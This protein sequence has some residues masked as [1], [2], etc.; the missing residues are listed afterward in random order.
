MVKARQE[1][2]GGIVRGFTI[3]S[4]N[5]NQFDAQ[6]NLASELDKRLNV[7]KKFA[8]EKG[9][10]AAVQRAVDYVAGNAP[11][12]H[13]FATAGNEYR[14]ELVESGYFEG[15]VTADTNNL[16]DKALQEAQLNVIKSK[17]ESIATQDFN[18]ILL[19]EKLRLDAGEPGDFNAAAGQI[20][21][22]VNG[23]SDAL[24]GVDGSAALDVKATLAKTGDTYYK[25]IGELHVEAQARRQKQ[26]D[27]VTLEDFQQE[28]MLQIATDGAK[29]AVPSGVIDESTGTPMMENTIDAVE[30]LIEQKV[31]MMIGSQVEPSYLATWA[32]ETLNLAL[33]TLSQTGYDRL[34]E[35]VESMSQQK[36][37]EALGK[38]LR[39]DYVNQNIS[40]D[41]ELQSIAETLENRSTE[42]YNS[43][44]ENLVKII[45]AK[46]KANENAEAF[47]VSEDNKAYSQAL[48]KYT[49]AR[50]RNEKEAAL[51]E[52]ETG[53]DASGQPLGFEPARHSSD[54]Q[55]IRDKHN[56]R[57]DD[58]SYDKQVHSQ[59]VR[60]VAVGTASVADV[61]KAF[62]DFDINLVQYNTLL[63][64]IETEQDAAYS[65]NLDRLRKAFGVPQLL[66]TPGELDERFIEASDDLYQFYIQEKLAGTLDEFDLKTQTDQL[67]NDYD[68]G[69][70]F[71][72]SRVTSAKEIRKS[73]GLYTSVVAGFARDMNFNDTDF[74]NK[75]AND[76]SYGLQYY[77]L[78]EFVADAADNPRYAAIFGD[79]NKGDLLS[80]IRSSQTGIKKIHPEL[81]TELDYINRGQ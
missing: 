47:E 40:E 35:N 66:T 72:D 57:L 27:Y 52:L 4:V 30:K 37:H 18:N 50:T 22:V 24:V 41:P 17:L 33:D 28:M 67:I 75:L 71:A 13:G 2:R 29:R 81:Q 58:T 3:P 14:K 80:A 78:L 70:V 12:L 5:F 60:E 48:H 44:N 73:M 63:D 39:N 61:E 64:K 25:S 7:V 53:K 42:K 62:N 76:G 1:Y 68:A 23:L 51:T 21:A 65:E 55:A 69:S 31:D 49:T 46:I 19:N 56:E 26:A 38:F 10:A 43:Y 79:V 77:M 9:G 8:M 16:F 36:L 54:L 6:T 20:T 74:A 45:E 11:D 59:L 34:A 32:E 15:K